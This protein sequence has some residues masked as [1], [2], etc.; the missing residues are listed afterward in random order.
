MALLLLWIAVPSLALVILMRCMLSPHFTA[1]AL[2]SSGPVALGLI[3]SSRGSLEI[4]L[5]DKF[6]INLLD[7]NIQNF[8]H[9]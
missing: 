2:Y 7:L 6:G 1:M 5:P 9:I 4:G 8:Y 3:D